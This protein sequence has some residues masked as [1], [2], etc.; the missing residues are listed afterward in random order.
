MKTPLAS[1][2]SY[3]SDLAHC[4]RDLLHVYFKPNT[5]KFVPATIDR[6]IRD[7]IE[8]SMVS[9]RKSLKYYYGH[10]LNM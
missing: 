4:L 8:I 10:A 9:G 7:R 3:V 6:T 2:T 5:F 1:D